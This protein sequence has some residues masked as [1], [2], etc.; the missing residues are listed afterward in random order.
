MTKNL[1][2]IE[3]IKGNMFMN[4]DIVMFDVHIEKLIDMSIEEKDII[5]SFPDIVEKVYDLLVI[6]PTWEFNPTNTHLRSDDQSLSIDKGKLVDFINEEAYFKFEDLSVSN[7]FLSVQ[8][9][10]E[11][12]I[13]N[14]REA[15]DELLS[16]SDCYIVTTLFG[17]V[18]L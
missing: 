2:K 7:R 4:T 18:V 17:E 11:L 5:N 15:P 16:K 9:P 12:L 8:L 13:A 1:K 6:G 14:F 3:T 10:I